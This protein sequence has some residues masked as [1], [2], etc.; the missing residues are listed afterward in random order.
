MKN[1]IR[2][3]ALACLLLTGC[4][5]ETVPTEPIASFGAGPG[6]IDLLSDEPD[7]IGLG[8]EGELGYYYITPSADHSHAN[9]RYIDKESR[10]DIR[11]FHFVV[12][13]ML[14]EDFVLRVPQYTGADIASYAGEGMIVCSRQ[15]YLNSC[16]AE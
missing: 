4:G 12:E 10:Q 1:R 3:A 14:G 9:L 6:P 8:D 11:Q 5:Q 2:A 15:D 7:S 16:A 13:G